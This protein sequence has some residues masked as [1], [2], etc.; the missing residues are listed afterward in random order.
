[1]KEKN[2][3][4]PMPNFVLPRLKMALNDI[5]TCLGSADKEEQDRYRLA[6]VKRLLADA[7]NLQALDA[8]LEDEATDEAALAKFAELALDVLKHIQKEKHRVNTLWLQISNPT[9]R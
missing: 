4:T 8:D 5:L 9:N 3:C 1:M 2:A 6:D 7:D